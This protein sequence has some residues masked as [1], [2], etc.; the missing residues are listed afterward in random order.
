MSLPC[1]TV[2]PVRTQPIRAQ[3]AGARPAGRAQRLFIGALSLLLGVGMGALLLALGAFGLFRVSDW[4]APGLTVGRVPVGGM[5][6]EEA[7]EAVDRAWNQQARLIVVDASDPTRLWQASPAEFGLRVDSVASTALAY[8][9]GRDANWVQGL[10]DLLYA[11]QYGSEIAP[12][13]VFDEAT[14]EASLRAWA[15]L[16]SVEPVE[17]ILEVRQAEV[18]ASPGRPGKA[19]DV[20]ATLNLLRA[21]PE[22]AYLTYQLVPLIFTSVPPQ[23]GDVSAAA[24]EVERLLASQPKLRAY[25]P[26]TGERFE[27]SPERKAIASWLSIERQPGRFAVGLDRSA[28]RRDV[29]QWNL[30]LGPERELD[31]EQAVEAMARALQGSEAEVLVIRYHERSHVVRPGETWVSIGVQAGMPY[32][33]IL[34]ANPQGTG[35]NP[36]PGETLVIPPRDAMLR[37]PV[38]VDKRIVI[39]ISQQHLWAYQD[40]ELLRDFVISTGIARSPTLPGIFQVQTHILNAYASNWDLYMPHFMGIYEAVPGFWNGIHG[41]PLLSNGVRLWANVLGRPASYGCIILDLPSAEW[42]YH[43]ADEGVVVEIQ[44]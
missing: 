10:S 18:V 22:S 30:D 3:H 19:L 33:K 23:I 29:M 43:W 1:L 7:A 15:G 21:D 39:S 28:I 5:R 32:W 35:R 24:A 14:A 37:L 9:V 26:V 25:D 36:I 38:V 2:D 44:R 41:L 20:R 31:V 6:S 12:V 27:W 42:L 17:A 8:Q 4:I 34:E 40:G 11:L 16:T 13:V